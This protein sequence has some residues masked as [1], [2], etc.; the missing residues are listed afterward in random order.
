MNVQ[1]RVDSLDWILINSVLAVIDKE[2][3]HVIVTTGNF[4]FLAAWSSR[5]E[6][7]FSRETVRSSYPFDSVEFG[8]SRALETGLGLYLKKCHLTRLSGR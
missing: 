3:N 5:Q 6:V 2:S 1:W 4:F 7:D 8:L